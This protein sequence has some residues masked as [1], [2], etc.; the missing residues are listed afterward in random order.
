MKR[1][2]LLIL[3]LLL[4]LVVSGVEI[5]GICYNLNEE[6]ETAEVT[7]GVYYEGSVVIPGTITY[8]N[9]SYSVIS[10]GEKAF[11]NCQRL[12]SVNI[13]NGVKAIG[14]SAFSSCYRLTSVTIPNS[15]TSIG[16]YAFY[17]CSLIS[18][19]IPNGVTSIGNYTFSWN[20][21]MTSVT[22]PNSVTTIGE[23]AFSNCS[24]LTSVTIPSSV[25][26]IEYCAFEKCSG[27]T[28]LTL[29]NNVK[30]IGVSAFNNCTSLTSV[31]IPNSV[32]ELSYRAFNGCS[33][34]TSV[35]VCN[36]IPLSIDEKTFSNRANAILY[37]PVGSKETYAAADY[38]KEFKEIIE[39]NILVD[40]FLSDSSPVTIQEGNTYIVEI[41]SGNGN[42]TVE[43]NNSTVATAEISGNNISINALS[44]GSAKITVTDLKSG[45]TACINVT[46]TFGSNPDYYLTCPDNNHPHLID[47]GLPSGV[48][49]ACCNINASKPEEAGNYYAWGET[50]PN[51]YDYSPLYSM[52]A[53]NIVGKFFMTKYCTDSESGIVDNKITLDLCDDV[54]QQQLGGNLRMPTSK[55][56]TELFEKCTSEWTTINGVKGRKFTGPNGGSIF[57]PTTGIWSYGNLDYKDQMGEYWSRSLY[58]SDQGYTYYCYCAKFLYF[59]EYGVSEA[60]EERYK[61]KPVRAVMVPTGGNQYGLV[62]F[63]LSDS[64]IKVGTG[65]NKTVNIQVGNGVYDND[66]RI[67]QLVSTSISNSSITVTGKQPGTTLITVSDLRS[68]QSCLL[69]TTVSPQIESHASSVDLGLPSGTKWA[70]CNLGATDPWEV[71]NYYAWGETAPKNIYSWDTYLYGTNP[72]DN[73]GADNIG[74][75]ISGTVY[76]VASAV[77]GEQWKMPTEEQ[78]NELLEQ[79]T[80][81]WT[82]AYK[83]NCLKVTGPNGNYILLP[84]AGVSE[85]GATR[86]VG[87]RG[88]YWTSKNI[89]TNHHSLGKY[90]YASTLEVNSSGTSTSMNWRA[91]G[92]CVRPVSMELIEADE[93]LDKLPTPDATKFKATKIHERG[94]TARWDKVEGALYYDI[95]VMYAD[96]NHDFTVYKN[97]TSETHIEVTGLEPNMSYVF[98]VRARNDNRRQ[99]SDWSDFIP[100]AVTTMAVDTTPTDL[101]VHSIKGIDGSQTLTQGYTYHY[102][103]WIANRSEYPWEGSFYLKDGYDYLNG[104]HGISIPENSVRPIE[105]DYTPECSGTKELVLYYKTKGNDNLFP[106]KTRNGDTNVIVVEVEGDNTFNSGLKLSAA[107]DCPEFIQLGNKAK[108]VAS[109]VN[110]S[111]GS[112]TGTL[113]ITD[114]GLPIK[115]KKVSLDSG[116]N[117]KLILNEWTP[118]TI[119]MHS[120]GVQ[121]KTDKSSYGRNLV[122]ENEFT[123]PISV[124]VLP[125]NVVVD[126]SLATITHVTKDVVPSEVTKGSTVNYYFRLTDQDGNRLKGMRL[127]FRCSGSNNAPSTIES[128]PSDYNGIT[129]LTLSAIEENPIADRGETVNLKCSALLKNDNSTVMYE[130]SD[131]ELSLT[132]HDSPNGIT[133]LENVENVK[134]EVDLGASFK[135]KENLFNIVDFSGGLTRPFSYT[136]KYNDVNDTN[137]YHSLETGIDGKISGKIDFGGY[138]N[139]STGLKGSVRQTTTYN[140]SEKWKTYLAI[141][142]GSLE[143]VSYMTNSTTLRIIN[144]IESWAGK[145]YGER[146]FDSVLV[147]EET[148]NTATWG[149][150]VKGEVELLKP[151]TELLGIFTGKTIP[152]PKRFSSSMNGEA[153]FTYEPQ[154][155][156]FKDGGYLYGSS[157]KMKAEYG[158]EIDVMVD[159]WIEPQRPIWRY[160]SN[161]LSYYYPKISSL[162]KETNI[163]GGFSFAYSWKEEE[164]YTTPEKTHLAEISNTHEVQSATTLSVDNLRKFICSD[165]MKNHPDGADSEGSIV[166]S[167]SLK[168][169]MTSKGDWLTDMENFA[170]ES[171]I[172][173]KIVSHIYPAFN[174]DGYII[175]TPFE[176]DRIWD[177]ENLL[178]YLQRIP[179]NGEYDI[180][181]PLKISMQNVSEFEGKVSIPIAKIWRFDVGISLDVD[182]FPSETYYSV[183]DKC[184]LPVVLRPVSSLGD[185][186]KTLTS[187]LCNKIKNMFSKQD[188]DELEEEYKKIG[189][190]WEVNMTNR[191]EIFENITSSHSYNINSR[192]IKNKP[193]MVA[194]SLQ[195]DICTFKFTVN[196][197]TMNFDSGTSVKFDHYYPAGCLFGFTEEGDTLF[198]ISEVCELNA[199]QASDTLKT[200]Q[201]GKI[202]LETYIGADDLT[203]FGFPETHPLGV[204]YSEDGRI[205]QYLGPAGT[206]LMVDK[207]GAYM[208]ATSVNNDVEA[209]VINAMLDDETGLLHVNVSDNIGIKGSTLKVYVNNEQRE[210]NIISESS[211]ELQLTE[212]EK[213]DT[214]I[215]DISVEDLAGNLGHLY[216]IFNLEDMSLL[217]DVN[218]DKYLNV[219]DVTLI[220]NHILKESSTFFI[221]K[222]ADINYDKN[223]TITDAVALVNIILSGGSTSPSLP[224]S[225]SNT[226]LNM[227]IGQKEMVVP[228]NGNGI[229]TVVSSD[230]RVAT[231]VV[232]RG[233]I[234]DAQYGEYMQVWVTA[235]G[236]GFAAITVTDTHTG[237]TAKIRVKVATPTLPF[238]LSESTISIEAGQSIAVDALDGSGQYTVQSS[239]A[240]VATGEAID[241]YNIIVYSVSEGT[242]TITVTDT[243]TGE[244]ATIEVTVMETVSTA[245]LQLSESSVEI[246]SGEDKL[247]EITSGNGSY[248]VTSSDENIAIASFEGSSVKI[249]AV[250]EGTAT[251]TVTDT[252]T[253]ETATI[254]VT[255]PVSSR[256]ELFSKTIGD[257][258]YTIYKEVL[259]ESDFHIN[260]DGW[261]CYKS[262]LTLELKKD[263][264]TNSYVVDENIYLDKDYNKSQR[265]CLF[266]DF[267]SNLMYIFINSKDSRNSYSMDGYAYRSSL[268]NISFAKETVFS[269]ANWGWWP[270]FTYENQLIAVQHFSYAGYYA[271]TSTLNSDGT[272]TTGRGKSTQPNV[273]ESLSDQAGNVYIVDTP[274]PVSNLICPDDNHPHMIDLGLPSGTKWACCNVGADKPE[275]YGGY[276]A[277]G[278]T[279]EKDVYNQVTYLYCTGE[280]NDDDGWYDI[281]LQYQN[282]GSDI[283]GT[284]YDVA[285]VKWGG[286]Q[287][288]TL[289]QINELINNCAYEFTEYKGVKG[290]KFTSS[291]GVCLFLPAAGVRQNSGLSTIGYSGLYWSNTQITNQ[292]KEACSLFLDNGRIFLYPNDSRV[293]GNSVRPVSK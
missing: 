103:V 16:N 158:G 17:N 40:L 196:D 182:F 115:E 157:R 200:T 7:S 274:S 154:K 191:K 155:V 133:A 213:A 112:W 69:Q 208:M 117:V 241:E 80:T 30:K 111:E 113:Y 288:P 161:V 141:L 48:K 174:T 257:A 23:N 198:V 19:K 100:N 187:D 4:P 170:L 216:Q 207:L 220:V 290:G 76:D 168:S 21:S 179:A 250:G 106:V 176:H 34:L 278:E 261:K 282:I 273:F 203:P 228:V 270:Y 237:E 75:D 134:F 50:T 227:E 108:I 25:T 86:Q 35:T 177:D 147:P 287:M 43:S 291:N 293:R 230:E 222:N 181:N 202:Q 89:L 127:L 248:T 140:E 87:E 124:E 65:D 238:S 79:C 56:L 243:Q 214:L 101:V 267:N 49:W 119:G 8:E 98:Q 231:A 82:T 57:L 83:V 149:Y 193:A 167:H 235:V 225:L 150:N 210:V 244:K 116:K 281:N 292:D 60:S 152:T 73:D 38:W 255:V 211:F 251:I 131:G 31:T 62:D 275:G 268:G 189:K 223:I 85:D 29:S 236:G 10:I 14:K 27:L 232:E 212:E 166:I 84:A 215:L 99:N 159:K 105:C 1:K 15:V 229:Y 254:E 114:N 20:S 160:S 125:E 81:T 130:P 64:D 54:A 5:E 6:E 276:Y 169:K 72:Y 12:T 28:T 173:R 205:W 151:S 199:V 94:F 283:S 26:S 262:R 192:R 163:S 253:R 206:T 70:T 188:E 61:C 263:G 59:D 224:F 90:A 118:E 171:D 24:K 74:L 46:V 128:T 129:V 162:M 132:I 88:S 126:A 260:P 47:L 58:Y 144:T 217:G 165:W 55:E 52:D 92:A 110:E 175:S 77:W 95:V 256:E 280:D 242:A 259:D 96:G 91:Y 45:Q 266:F 139:V 2:L 209:P 194:Q 3:V 289:N 137:P 284:I 66:I 138:F 11:Y 67:P 37:V 258:E 286:W 36:P 252:K 197:G 279:E 102:N 272:W 277:W 221:K 18:V 41:T 33:S 13:P 239:N 145:K 93:P 183:A 285:H 136:W 32:T 44:T 269:G 219:T 146:F 271:M 104:W 185:V 249:T 120:I 218:G 143:S 184:F 135:V 156:R 246:K 9:V 201:Q 153:A 245:P 109:V 234:P 97:S 247:V 142:L 68:G 190:R 78:C 122:S 107:T 265:P 63:K 195:K 226:K 186:I 233:S 22:I 39:T 172:N 180:K 204:Y 51:W 264:N 71:G 53:S 121:Y 178:G 164:M 148:Y 123:N 42:Y 240:S